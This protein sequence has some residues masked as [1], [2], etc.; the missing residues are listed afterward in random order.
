MGKSYSDQDSAHELRLQELEKMVARFMQ[1]VQELE[2]YVQNKVQKIRHAEIEIQKIKESL[3]QAAV[4]VDSLVVNPPSAATLRSWRKQETSSLTERLAD[5]FAILKKPVSFPKISLPKLRAPKFHLPRLHFP[6]VRLPKFHAPKI[7]FPQFHLPKLSL[8]PFW[9]GL[10]HLTRAAIFSF[11]LFTIGFFIMN[12]NA[13][14]QI[15]MAWLTQFSGASTESP[16]TDLAAQ[17]AAP[18]QELFPV[19]NNKED[20]KLQIPDL[21]LAVTPPDN[22]LII[23]KLN[24]NIP[25]LDTDLAKLANADISVLEDSFQ[26]D[27]KNGVIHFPGTANPGEIGNVFITGHSSYYLWDEGDYKDVFA[28]LNKLVVGDDI[29]VYYNQQKYTYKV[30]EKREVKK[31]DVSIL[32]QGDEKIL[33]LMTC[34]P[35]GTNLRRLVIVAEQQIG[36]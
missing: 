23:P 8:K 12:A 29:V 9:T 34:T 18:I 21:N 5:K 17:Q 1:E 11:L 33:T 25:I 32:E 4:E 36:A 13:Y 10:R 2:S 28:R 6:Q 16:L 27:L 26:E 20:Q 30:R 31:D 3:K 35:V 15:T 24:K 7:R 14:S 22:R 19:S